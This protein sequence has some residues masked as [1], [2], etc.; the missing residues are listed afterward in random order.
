[1]QTLCE[2]EDQPNMGPCPMFRTQIVHRQALLEPQ[3]LP[4]MPRSET[5]D[6]L[7]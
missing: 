5:S 6:D 3:K 2:Q 7:Q 1:M 4:H